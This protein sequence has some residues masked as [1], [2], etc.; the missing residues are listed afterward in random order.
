M[1]R[2]SKERISAE[3][4][5]RFVT[6]YNYRF[7][8][9]VF[10]CNAPH[11]RKFSPGQAMSISELLRRF[12]RGQRVGVKLHEINLVPEGD[13][14]ENQ[15][16]FDTAAPE[17]IHDVVDV[18]AYENEIRERKA[19]YRQRTNKTEKENKEEKKEEKDESHEDA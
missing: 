10:N 14:R 18:Q 3:D 15:E 13:P 8:K 4:L 19:A 1:A 5:P 16:D 9:H 17:D 7:E 12:E 2:K 11:C 6:Q